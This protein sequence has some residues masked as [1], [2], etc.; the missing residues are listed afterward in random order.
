MIQDTE[1]SK[2][3]IKRNESHKCKRSI[4]LSKLKESNEKF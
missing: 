1:I 4:T 3:E 2:V